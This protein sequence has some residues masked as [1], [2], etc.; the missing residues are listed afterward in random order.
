MEDNFKNIL[1]VVLSIVSSISELLPFVSSIESNGIINFI[2]KNKNIIKEETVGLLED[3]ER[4]NENETSKKK[5]IKMES[6]KSQTTGILLVDAVSQT[7]KESPI[8]K[9]KQ[10]VDAVT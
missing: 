9:E 2:L 1:L 4:G 8:Q 6:T 5:P 3:L 10:G 7:T